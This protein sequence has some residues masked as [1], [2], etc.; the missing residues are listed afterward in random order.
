[1]AQTETEYLSSCIEDL[2]FKGQATHDYSVFDDKLKF[3][4]TT[5]NGNDQ[6]EIEKRMLDVKGT[7]AFILHTYQ[8]WVLVYTVSGYN[9]KKRLDIDSWFEF[10]KSLPSTILDVLIQT[11]G[12]F[13][14]ELRTA[15]LKKSEIENFSEPASTEQ[16]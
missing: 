4:L 6:L 2:I 9:G 5:L 16:D 11:Q 1:M 13:E 8:L 7:N 12:K 10:I 14:K 3:T 15:L